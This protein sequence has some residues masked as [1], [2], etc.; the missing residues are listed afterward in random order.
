[1][2]FLNTVPLPTTG[3]GGH[4]SFVPVPQLLQGEFSWIKGLDLLLGT[5]SL[6]SVLNA[7]FPSELRT[8]TILVRLAFSLL[9]TDGLEATAAGK[10][11]E[12]VVKGVAGVTVIAKSHFEL[13]SGR[14]LVGYDD[15]EEEEEEIEGVEVVVNVELPISNL[16]I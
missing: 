11:K 7:A 13:M 15:E 14:F 6:V 1:M 5:V 16:D 9:P 3:R 8:K 10:S 12:A 2:I 4:E